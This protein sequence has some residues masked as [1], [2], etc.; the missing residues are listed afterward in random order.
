MTARADTMLGRHAGTV[1][2]GAG[3]ANALRHISA[4]R[5]HREAE[6]QHYPLKG[7]V[8]PNHHCLTSKT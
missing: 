7:R 1:E 2:G 4:A 6:D 8:A 3:F 5:G